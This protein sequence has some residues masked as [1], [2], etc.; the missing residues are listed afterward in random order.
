LWYFLPKTPEGSVALILL[1]M[2]ICEV[3]SACTLTLLFH[4]AI[5]PHPAGGGMGR[6]ALSTRIVAIALPVGLNSLLGNLMGTWTAALIPRALVKSG[7]DSVQALGAFGILRGMTMPLLSLPAAVIG[8][9]CLV[10]LPKMAQAHALGRHDL[11]RARLGKALTATSLWVMP[12]SALIAV[13]APTLG[14]L[15]FR[16]SAAG[17]MAI[18]FALAVALSCFESVLIV[19]LNALGKQAKVAAHALLC[20]ALQLA[21]TWGFMS[22][23]GG[24]FGYALAMIVSSLVGL[25]LSGK[26]LKKAIGMKAR[27]FRWLIAPGLAALLSALCANLMLPILSPLGELFACGGTLVFGGVVYLTALAAMGVLPGQ[28]ETNF[29]RKP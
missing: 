11:C 17:D 1:G 22:A 4:R 16:Q 20:G 3:F 5:G 9:L 12:T 21:L 2:I 24:L 28:G 10:L 14:D 15:L 6:K 29:P 27:W 13:V 7:A 8:A 25:Y 26:A 19:S 18:P 23:G